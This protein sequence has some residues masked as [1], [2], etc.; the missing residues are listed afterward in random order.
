[1]T[2]SLRGRL[3]LGVISLVVI[4]LLI[5][6]VA[7]YAFL[8]QFLISR[9]DGQLTSN[10]QA[11]VGVLGGPDEGPRSSFGYRPGTVFEL[12]SANGT[13][14]ATP[15]VVTTVGATP[16]NALPVLPHRL[17]NSGMDKP[18]PAYTVEGTGGVEQYRVIDWPEDTFNGNFVVL[19]IPLTDE[20]STLS[21]MLVLE[22]KISVAVV[23]AT[24]ILALLIVRIGLRP[25]QRMGAVANDIAAGDLTRRVEPATPKTEI[26]RLG[27]AL[28]GMLSQIEAAFAERTASND[29]LRRVIADAS[30]ELRTPLT[31]IR[32]YAEMLRRGAAESPTD[33]ESARRRIEQEAIRMTGLVDDLLV[34]ARLDQGR[35]LDKTA[36]DLRTIANDAVA[37]ARVVAPRREISL[38]ANGPVIVTG[39]DTRL[40]QVMGNLMRNA[41]VHT[42]QQSP[43]EVAVA[44]DAGLG[45]MSVADHGPGLSEGDVGRI[46]EPF[47]RADPSR[48]RDSG[49]AG[50][51]LSIVSAVVSAHGGRVKVRRT[52]GG[53]AT[54]EVELPLAQPSSEIL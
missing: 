42:P 41:L 21:Q 26:G 5:S 28:N 1:M 18:S 11:A 39:D 36:V 33:S 9:V 2:L 52:D 31:S 34:L 25:L 30:H 13:L 32:G 51:G 53:G 37:D 8:Q 3:L 54:F 14:L 24:V 10:Y 44:T 20:L 12:V 19:A 17:L 15:K 23:A 45:R 29:R 35:P 16:S 7:T 49:G 43:I 27:L 6:N 48:S 4:G 38:S 47:Y 50:L 46:F 22:L 40:R